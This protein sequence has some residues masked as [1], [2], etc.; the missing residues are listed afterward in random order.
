VR[1]WD[2]SGADGFVCDPECALDSPG[3]I[4]A[5]GPGTTG[6]LGDNFDTAQLPFSSAPVTLMV[7]VFSGRT[8]RLRATMKPLCEKF[9]ASQEGSGTLASPALEAIRHAAR[10]GRG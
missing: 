8:S 1:S 4:P 3:G 9:E 7:D 2:L 10:Q 5:L 6:G